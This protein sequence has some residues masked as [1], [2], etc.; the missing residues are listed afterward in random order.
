MSAEDARRSFFDTNILIYRT[1]QGD[2]R[3]VRARELMA[4]GGLISV[5][6]LNEFVNVSRKKLNLDWQVIEQRLQL[7]RGLCDAVLPLTEE[8]HEAAVDIAIRYRYSI[9]DALMIASALLASCDTLYSEDMQDGQ[10]IE[11][12]TIRNPVAGSA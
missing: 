8:T 5:Q 12:L 6:M 4:S 3:Q 11:G 9:Y 10:R 7:I 2:A 1:A